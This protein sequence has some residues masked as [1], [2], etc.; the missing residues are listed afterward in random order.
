MRPA[1]IADA[2][3]YWERY[4]SGEFIFGLGTE[5][6][7][8]V[9]QQ[10]PPART[11]ADLGAGSESLLWSIPLDAGHLFAVDLDPHRLALLR[12]Y[13]AAR[14]PRGAYQT[15]LKL[16]GRN[17]DDFAQR[18]DRLAA[19]II[20]DCLAGYPTPLRAGCADLVTQFGLLGLATSHAQFLTSWKACHEPLA[21]GGWAAG[22]NWNATAKHGRIQ[23]SQQLYTAACAE[24][25]MTPLLVTRVPITADPDFDSVWIYL[26]RKT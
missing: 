14:R 11:W 12:D 6:I 7:L 1:T 15:A 22:A 26:G 20:A 5:H 17:A 13:A 3:Q 4:Y 19:T 21:A 8:A 9:L 24:T 25:G 16:C 18:C 10:I 23:L 2:N